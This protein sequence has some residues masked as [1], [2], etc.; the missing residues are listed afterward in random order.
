MADPLADPQVIVGSRYQLERELGRGGM[1]IVYQ[2]VDRKHNR[3]VAVKV[4]HRHVAEALGAD[5]FHREIAIAARLQHRGIVA[6]FDS[7]QT[8]DSLYYVMPLVEGETLRSRLTGEPRLEVLTAMAIAREVAEALSYAHRKGVVHRD[9]KPENILLAEGHA[10]VADFGIARALDSAGGDRLT[11]TGFAL[12]TPAYMSPE[13]AAG[14]KH[15]DARSDLYS[16]GCML[17]EM[18]AGVPPFVGPTAQ[19]TL[20]R[21]LT[22]AAPSVRRARPDVPPALERVVAKALAKEPDGR[23]A[24]AEALLAELVAATPPT[25]GPDSGRPRRG[26]SRRGLG[27]LSGL[28]VMAGV[29]GYAALTSRGNGAGLPEI[30]SLAVLPIEDLSGDPGQAYFADGMTDALISNLAE[31]RALKRVISRTSMMRYK[32]STKSLPEIARELEVDA[33]VEGTVLRSGGRVRVVA[34]L[35]PASTD[36]PVWTKDYNRDLS[37]VLKLQSELARAVAE[38][39]RARL[40]PEESARLTARARP[41]KPE[42]LEAYLL[43]NHHLRTNEDDLRQA[44]SYFERAVGLDRDYAAAYAG[45]SRAWAMRGVWGSVKH[46][47]VAGVAREAALQAVAL[48]DLLPAG[49]IE[50]ATVKLYDY[51]WSGAEHELRRALELDPNNARA[52][53]Q[54]ADLLMALERHDQA[55]REIQ[56]AVQLDPLSSFLESRYARVLYRARRYQEALPHVERALALDPNPGNAMP[57][58]IKAELFAEMGRYQDATANLSLA[59]EHGGRVNEID[60]V[61]AMIDARAGMRAQALRTLE[62]LRRTTD[63]AAFANASTAYAYT[64]LGD[65]DRAFHILFRL[66]S[67]RD[68]LASHLKADP[69]LEPLHDDPRWSELLSKMNL[70]RPAPGPTR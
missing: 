70:L 67:E 50:L 46:S 56:R 18:L 34:K 41:I 6:L 2:A 15:V 16:L 4:F 49:H 21:R 20:V 37:D 1:A 53:Q 54:Y 57:Y 35:I 26:I 47:E 8:A 64:A 17:Y 58:W 25:T 12:G 24:T 43:G 65:K 63:S 5:R 31:I 7:S 69:Q 33:V 52:H 68:N 23:H 61:G 60:A 59:R 29:A 48:D 36:S 42:A 45:L 51:D 9:I 14:V 44:I 40:T 28:V 11:E 30:T 27:V 13:Q 19:A 3:R 62:R 38:E 39:I 55:I 22:D 32:G 10:L 66:V